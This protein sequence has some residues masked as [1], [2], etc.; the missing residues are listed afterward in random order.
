MRPLP[1]EQRFE[2]SETHSAVG[3]LVLSRRLVEGE[4]LQPIAPRQ[5]RQRAEEGIPAGDRKPRP[6][7][8]GGAADHHH[9][10]DHGGDEEQPDR[11]RCATIRPRPP[12]ASPSRRRPLANT[13][14]PL[15]RRR[16]PLAARAKWSERQDL[17][18]RPLDPQSSALP[19]CA[20]LR[21]GRPL[22]I[23]RRRSPAIAPERALTEPPARHRDGISPEQERRRRPEKGADSA[24]WTGRVPKEDGV[25]RDWAIA[26]PVGAFGRAAVK[27]LSPC[28]RRTSLKAC[29]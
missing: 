1:P 14:R 12:R 17:N 6:G 7:R 19:G 4:I 27:R 18:L 22:A 2:I 23:R 20:T 8:A 9:A 16:P 3:H 28:R 5:R 21:R 29:P 26:D 25:I 10:D 11:R 24:P 15:I 13:A